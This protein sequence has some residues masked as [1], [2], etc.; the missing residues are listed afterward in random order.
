MGVPS[1][2]MAMVE[3]PVRSVIASTSAS[4]ALGAQV[5]VADHEAGLVVLHA[6]HHGRLSSIDCEPKMKLSPPQRASAIARSAPETDCISALVIGT[7]IVS[8]DASG[9]AGRP[10]AARPGSEPPAQSRSTLRRRCRFVVRFGSSKVLA[11]SPARLVQN[12]RH[13]GW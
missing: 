6:A 11:E 2:V 10:P 3:W 4:V 9:L 8:G 1:S 13:I 5:R 12:R 7:L